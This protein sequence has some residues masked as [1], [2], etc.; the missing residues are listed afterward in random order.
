MLRETLFRTSE[1]AKEDR[2][3]HWRDL[4]LTTVCPMD[5]ASENADDF[6]AEA[7]VLE[8]GAIRIWPTTQQPL[9]AQRTRRLIKQA[10]PE[11]L[12]LVLPLR[13]SIGIRQAGHEAVHGPGE[14]YIIDTS[15]PCDCVMGDRVTKAICLEIPK[16]ALPL[17]PDRTA[18]IAARRLSGRSGVGALLAG[19]LTGAVEEFDTFREPDAPR[20]ERAVTDLTSATLAHRLDAQGDLPPETRTQML[21]RHIRAFIQQRLHD[22][23][24]APPVIAAAHHIS[25]SYL[26]RLFQA[27]GDTVS[28]WIRQQRLERARSHL[29]DSTLGH[30]PIHLIGTRVGFTDPA[31]FVRTFRSAHGLTPGAYRRQAINQG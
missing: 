28:G 13:G 1:V 12:H 4:M 16:K 26:Y 17:H 19:F 14:M 30:L 11:I 7:R 27:E 5:M 2:F 24:L 31:V 6:H 8:I 23:A 20:L 22:P 25:V 21:T 10:D 29:A 15:I 18:R 9:Q 3:D